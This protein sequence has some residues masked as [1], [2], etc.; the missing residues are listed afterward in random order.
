MAAG[1]LLSLVRPRATVFRAC[2]QSELHRSCF[3]APA[4][5][6]FVRTVLAHLAHWMIFRRY[7]IQIYTLTLTTESGRME[8]SLAIYPY[9]NITQI[10]EITAE[11]SVSASLS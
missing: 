8:N 5:D 10:S 6:I 1:L 7:T 2:R 3:R 11:R 9:T 4:E